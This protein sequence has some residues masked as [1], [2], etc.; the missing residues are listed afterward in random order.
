MHNRVILPACEG[1]ASYPGPSPLRRDLVHTV[2]AWG[3]GLGMRLVRANKTGLSF[4]VWESIRVLQV[5]NFDGNTTAFFKLICIIESEDGNE[6]I[7]CV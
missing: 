1:L 5:P 4:L 6:T 3:R 2:Y 7:Q